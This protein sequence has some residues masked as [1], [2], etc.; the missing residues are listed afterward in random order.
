VHPVLGDMFLRLSSCAVQTR[1]VLTGYST[2]LTMMTLTIPRVKTGKAFFTLCMMELPDVR[3][4]V[5]FRVET[6]P[7]ENTNEPTPTSI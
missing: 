7:N 2:P 5:K 4:D 3:W 1:Q 6:I